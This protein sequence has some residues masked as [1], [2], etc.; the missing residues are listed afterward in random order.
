MIEAEICG[1][2]ESWGEYRVMGSTG[3]AGTLRRA[4][5]GTGG[6]LTRLTGPLYYTCVYH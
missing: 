3:A 1:G 2:G 4:E 5:D 6:V